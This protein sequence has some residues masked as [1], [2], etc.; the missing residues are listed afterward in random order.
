VL[1]SFTAP[2]LSNLADS[3][4]VTGGN[5]FPTGATFSELMTASASLPP[6]SA[7]RSVSSPSATVT[8]YFLTANWPRAVVTVSTL[9]PSRKTP[10]K[11]W[12]AVRSPMVM[13]TV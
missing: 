2:P 9:A 3:G 12:A 1:P 10:M 6:R 4:P 5:G 7:S 11:S 13:V 8:V